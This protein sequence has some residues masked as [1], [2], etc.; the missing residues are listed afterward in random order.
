MIIETEFL[1]KKKPLRKEVMEKHYST[2]LWDE[3]NLKK[4]YIFVELCKKVIL[5]LYISNNTE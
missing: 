5:H 2:T 3:M 1:Q 4:K